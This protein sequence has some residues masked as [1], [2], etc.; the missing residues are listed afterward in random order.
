M[1]HPNKTPHGNDEKKKE[2]EK[3]VEQSKTDMTREKNPIKEPETKPKKEDIV[4][5]TDRQGTARG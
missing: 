5:R 3:Q 2:Q 4:K 1:D